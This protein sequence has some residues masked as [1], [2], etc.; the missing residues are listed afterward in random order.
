M[1]LRA[2]CKEYIEG[3]GV[4]F[5]TG[6]GTLF[7]FLPPRFLTKLNQSSCILSERLIQ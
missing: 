3:P 1:R 2:V 5:P 4:C 6:A 7:L